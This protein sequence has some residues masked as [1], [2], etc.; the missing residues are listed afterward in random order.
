MLIKADALLPSSLTPLNR[1]AW[2]SD[3][4]NEY[5]LG[6]RA[7]IF[8]AALFCFISVIGSACVQTYWQM[9][10][11]RILLGVG[12]GAKASVVPVYAAEI[13]P[14]HIRGLYFRLL[15]LP[16]ESLNLF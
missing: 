14:A 6:R 4:L 10:A 16:A 13:A 11:C 8:V 3:P 7:A 9:L 5:L 15:L 12:M 2:L 1:G